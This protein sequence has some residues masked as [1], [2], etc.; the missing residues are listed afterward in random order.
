[1]KKLYILPS[2]EIEEMISDELL[3][4]I[5]KTDKDAD[6]GSGM[7]SKQRGSHYTHENLGWDY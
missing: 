2:I 5:S 6:Q 3:Q 4:T 1:M 7:D